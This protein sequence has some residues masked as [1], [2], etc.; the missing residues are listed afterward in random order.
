MSRIND[1]DLVEGGQL[2]FLEGPAPAVSGDVNG[3]G[4][5]DFRDI[6][7][8]YRSLGQYGENLPADIDG[9]GV[10]SIRDL[11]LVLRLFYGFGV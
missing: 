10:V 1:N 8:V 2:L 5:V 6:L 3:D 9:D 11:K 4:K 7:F